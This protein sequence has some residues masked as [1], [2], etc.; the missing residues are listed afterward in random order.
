MNDFQI[1]DVTLRD[2]SY[3]INFQFSNA[4]VQCIGGGLDQLKI[5]YIEIGHGMGI[6]ASGPR[7]GTAL[8]TDMEYLQAA[9]ES[10]H[11][12]KIGMFCVP[13][14]ATLEQ[15]EQLC[16]AGLDFVRVGTNV[17]VVKSSEPYIRLCKKMGITVMANY[18]KS[19]AMNPKQFAQE[20]KK[21][22]AYGA[23]IVYL[24]DSAGSMLPCDIQQYYEEIRKV[25]K[26][27][28]G[29]HGHD[30]LG[31]ALS[32]SLYAAELGF[33]L[34]DASLQGLGRSAGNTVLEHLA[35][36][37]MKM[38][39]KA[40]FN[41]H[42]LLLLGKK[43]VARLMQSNAI[44]PID[45]VCGLAGFHSSYLQAIHRC[46]GKYA[47]SPLDLIAEYAKVDKLDMNEEVLEEIAK[48]LP[49]CKDVLTEIDMHGYL[50]NEQGRA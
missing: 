49:H 1:M 21:T 48:T 16:A 30:N 19:Y 17:D 44:D 8:H 14:V 35:A 4:D 12:A 41:I 7:Y 13:G 43:Y 3:K 24:V 23:D 26:I 50:V 5:P 6:G 27:P 10:I 46:A 9:K 37:S 15:V 47:V 36:V 33:S 28:V 22:E 32:N 34:I 40:D 25:S 39:H 11:T 45:V 31:L 29:F 18:M 42:D 38:G 2:G 20:V